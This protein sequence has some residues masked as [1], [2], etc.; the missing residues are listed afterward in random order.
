MNKVDNIDYVFR[1]RIFISNVTIYTMKKL[2][3]LIIAAVIIILG[4]LAISLLQSPTGTPL[5]GTNPGDI[6]Q[7]IAAT[8]TLRGMFI[9]LP[10]R[11]TSGPQTLECALGLKDNDGNYYAIDASAVSSTSNMPMNTEFRVTGLLVPIEAISNDQMQK[12]NIKGIMKVS[13]LE[14]VKVNSQVTL[15]LNV[16]AAIGGSTLTAWAVTEDSRCASDVTCI[17]AGRVIV[18]LRVSSPSGDSTMQLEPG[19]TVT[20]E[21]LAL[22]LDD[23]KPYPI[24]THKTTDEE[25]RFLLTVRSR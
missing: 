15:R 5:P 14:E 11:D 4:A 12:Y 8:T 23:V 18:A 25:Y 22:T 6:P 7:P 3:I 10:H 20:T 2:Y 24:S 21:T 1:R 19:K 17:W 16:P 9:C 13:S